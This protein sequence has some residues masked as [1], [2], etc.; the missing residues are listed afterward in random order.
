MPVPARLSGLLLLL[1]LP[2]AG[3]PA[4]TP[5]RFPARRLAGGGAAAAHESASG[6]PSDA[7][8]AARRAT[9]LRSP[10]ARLVERRPL[11]G[12]EVVFVSDANLAAETRDALLKD[13][14][15]ALAA[16]FERDGWPKP[17][18]S[19]SPLHLAVL[20]GPAA[21]AAGWDGREK[22]GALRS[23]A[24][25][26]SAAGRDA[27][28]VLLDAVH[29]IA[30]LSVRQAAPEEAAWA[31]EGV[32][33]YLARRAAGVSGPPVPED[34]VFLDDAGSL[35]SPPVLAA[36]L[37]SL[38]ARLPRGAA[39]VRDAW[40]AAGLAPGDDA[41]SF[42]RDV[43]GRSG[44]AG[45][46]ADA[47]AGTV[48]S[49][50]ASA[51][52][53]RGAP[54]ASVARRAWLLAPVPAWGPAPLGW[55]RASLRTE[56]ERGG[57]E[58]TLPETG[59]RSARAVLFYRGDAGDFDSVPLAPGEARVL[60]AAGTSGVHV[61]LADGDGSEA[62]LRLRRV[63][64]YPA[65]LAASGAE[66]RGGAV[67]VAWSTTQHRDLLAWVIERREETPEGDGP[68]ERETLPTAS[69][70][71]EATGYLFVDR[72]APAGLRYRYRVLAL[73]TDGL[74]AEA[75]EARVQAR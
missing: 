17:F 22:D 13:L 20:S 18:S 6:D 34:D 24:A 10:Y 40:E 42:L 23:P 11:R 2:A 28:A 43:G 12:G 67:E 65:A 37:D 56:D 44:S 75:F 35:V 19:R 63:P 36:F 51:A 72:N 41:E 38:E 49:R 30:L 55:R 64:E 25:V 16:L 54:V 70:S 74:L 33:E 1:A 31:A 59:F 61:V 52:A 47:L 8:A 66:W 15:P 57:V 4:S 53:R 3:A 60:P 58:I 39:D 29:Q 5:V 32:A 21:S 26:V 71:P 73:T 27:A 7:A 9:I 69:E 48:V 50:L 62:T 68:A 46:V 45:G 14:P